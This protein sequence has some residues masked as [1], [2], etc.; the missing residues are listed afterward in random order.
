MADW[1]TVQTQIQQR[2]RQ[3]TEQVKARSSRLSH[4]FDALVAASL[5]RIM[6][7][8]EASPL[9]EQP[10][11]LR[12]LEA[13]RTST[14][15]EARGPSRVDTPALPIVAQEATVSPDAVRWF[16]SGARV[17]MIGIAIFLV[18]SLWPK[19]PASLTTRA[20]A[21]FTPTP[22]P[23]RT[24]AIINPANRAAADANRQP[25]QPSIVTLGGAAGQTDEGEAPLAVVDGLADNPL[26]A[27]T[28]QENTAGIAVITDTLAAGT[29]RVLAV[30]AAKAPAA[31]V[32]GGDVVLI[33]SALAA[34]QAATP[35]APFVNIVS[36]INFDFTPTP[37]PQ[38]TVL[39]S[40]T[41]TPAPV[42]LTPGR[43]WS[44]FQ[45]EIGNDHFW[46]GR[47]FPDFVGGQLASPN[48]QFGSTA[49]GR[50]RIHH[51]IDI[52]NPQGTP[53]RAATVGE[54]IHAGPDDPEL[55]GPYNG[56]YGNAVVIRLDQK[57]PVAGGEMN[58]FL[59]YGHLSEV[60][61]Q[62]GQRVQPDD[63]V[64]RVGMTGIAIGPHLHVEVR[65]GINDYEHSVNPYLWMTPLEKSGAVAV[66]LLT[67][68][69]R[70]WPGARLTLARFE[71]GKAVWAR[72]IETYRDDETIGP[73]PTWG[74]NGAMGS[75][76]PG[77]Y[78]LV[79]NVNGQ[80]IRTELTVDEGRT[81]FV[82]LRTE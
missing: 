25:A 73:D 63:I 16:S 68:D 56:F 34:G 13:L 82:E 1:S 9:R 77:A 60:L 20:A 39:A 69:G 31:A 27:E 40:P 65:L 66:R 18:F 71:G 36:T 46:I 44:N 10:Q 59:L 4:R 12:L 74:E 3:A 17:G 57:L 47:P 26:F 7:L 58:V 72:L 80:Q 70:T 81:T 61:V 62:P 79:A 14:P 6:I 21:Q 64:G 30:A 29:S 75:V 55:L 11:V 45:P 23:T 28:S 35:V 42:V 49:G 78:V 32:A 53:V 8:L 50:Y 51:G 52:S 22:T 76:P 33:D 43:L 54:V 24:L 19:S 15:D 2:T 5:L 37:E 41:P 48:Y 67:A 38:P